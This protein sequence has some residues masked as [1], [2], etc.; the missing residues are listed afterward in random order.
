MARH[1][2]FLTDAGKRRMKRAVETVEGRSAAEVVFSVRPASGHYRHIDFAVGAFLAYAGL[3]FMLFSPALVFSW[4]AILL[5]VLVLFA[6]G[7]LLSV[8]VSPLRRALAG[9]KRLS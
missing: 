1:H 9:S 5:I 6:T 7:T 2:P 4:I 3:A 8:V